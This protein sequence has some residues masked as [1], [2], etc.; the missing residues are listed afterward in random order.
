MQYLTGKNVSHR[1]HN[2]Q[3]RGQHENQFLNKCQSIHDFFVTLSYVSSLFPLSGT[4]FQQDLFFA[5]LYYRGEFAADK[6]K[7]PPLNEGRNCSFPATTLV[8]SLKQARIQRTSIR[9]FCN[10]KLP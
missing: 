9:G 3:D 8:S 7:N 2:N 6:Q 10:G 4:M 5:R 1:K